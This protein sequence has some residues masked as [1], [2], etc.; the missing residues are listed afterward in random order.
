LV[1]RVVAGCV[2]VFAAVGLLRAGLGSYAHDEAWTLEPALGRVILSEWPA[3]PVPIASLVAP[4]QARPPH[5]PSAVL[6][7]LHE[8]G[9]M[10]PPA[11]YLLLNAWTRMFGSQRFALRLA[12][13]AL[14]ALALLGLARLAQRLVP[15]PSAAGWAVALA[16]VAPWFGSIGVVLRPYVMA[17]AIGTWAT[18]AVLAS[19]GSRRPGPWRVA[20]VLLSSLGLYT[21]Y[22]YAFVLAW[23][24][25]LLLALPRPDASA[26]RGFARLGVLVLPALAALAFL[27]W[28]PSLREHLS[29]TSAAEFYFSGIVPALDWPARL[30]QLVDAFLV[31]TVV[32]YAKQPLVIALLALQLATLAVLLAPILARAVPPGPTPAGE[33][34]HPARLSEHARRFW[35]CAPL[36]PALVALGDLWR[37]THTLFVTKTAFM[38]FPLLVLLIVHAWHAVPSR[39]VS[40][41]GLGAWCLLL[42]GAT[43]GSLAHA[44]D[45]ATAEEFLAADL[46]RAD[47][48]DHL[49][50]LST[51][52][53]GELLPLLCTLRD[54][55][56]TKV[57][58]SL[59][60]E[61]ALAAATRELLEDP[62]ARRATL[63]N[64][65]R[66][67]QCLV[68]PSP[69]SEARLD[70]VVEQARAAGWAVGRGPPGHAEAL[71]GYDRALAI[72]S[73]MQGGAYEE[74]G[75]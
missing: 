34:R 42:A 64:L 11:Y 56:V 16:A 12:G 72:C 15:H 9:F 49:V 22:H 29:G 1:S 70:A 45:H 8:P 58:V 23:H 47:T 73:P 17:I 20:F 28:L 50:V 5:A 55:G 33:R 46:S 63:V 59:V 61:D 44:G 6:D 35:L 69:W 43:I 4:L 74:D 13:L 18:V 41:L 51:A 37:G 53:R 38:L 57:R 39:R 48:E 21:L 30:A 2:L 26:R 66:R 67:C 36:L 31:T 68:P 60:P 24:A 32:T 14:G 10:H 62:A 65:P 27:P 75:G 40:A 7:V 52:H 25:V 3:A 54:A 71:D 19:A